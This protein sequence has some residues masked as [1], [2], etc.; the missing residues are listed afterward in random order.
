MIGIGAN[1]KPPLLT[2]CVTDTTDVWPAEPEIVIGVVTSV[3][4]VIVARSEN[5]LST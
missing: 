2:D 3:G 1:Q 4:A 5:W